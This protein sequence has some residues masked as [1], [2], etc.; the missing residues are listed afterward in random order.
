MF[1]LATPSPSH[2]SVRR[3]SEYMVRRH[4]E[5]DA[6]TVWNIYLVVGTLF[7]FGAY[8]TAWAGIESLYQIGGLSAVAY[9]FESRGASNFSAYCGK[10]VNEYFDD[11]GTKEVVMAW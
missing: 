4:N 7:A 10:P 9:C 11:W 1:I 5:E 2:S 3:G 6:A 8:F